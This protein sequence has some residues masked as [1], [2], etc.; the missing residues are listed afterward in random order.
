MLGCWLQVRGVRATF[1]QLQS[2]IR[3]TEEYESAGKAQELDGVKK[4]LKD[5]DLRMESLTKKLKDLDG[6]RKV[7][8]SK[9]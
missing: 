8:D 9:M 4:L 5:Q 6:E 2:K 3:V 1:D 7:R